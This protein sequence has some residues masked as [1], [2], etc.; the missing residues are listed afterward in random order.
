MRTLGI[1][2][3]GAILALAGVLLGVWWSPFVIGIGIGIA[4]PRGRTAVPLG[5]A[6]GLLSWL[7]PLAEEHQRYGL[8]PTVSSLAAIMGFGHQAFVPV[9]ITLVVA[10]LLG[11]CG[12]WLASSTRG[13][14]TARAR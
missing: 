10:T 6:V 7:I 3:L 1:L 5:A 11:L 13:F 9:V 8:G 14:V 2:L 12:A 4:E